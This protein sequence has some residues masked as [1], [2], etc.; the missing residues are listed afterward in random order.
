MNKK[1]LYKEADLISGGFGWVFSCE[2]VE[3]EEVE[4]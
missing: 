2:G 3:V 1:E 4:E